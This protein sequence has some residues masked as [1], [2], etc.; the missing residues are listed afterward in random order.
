MN[1]LVRAFTTYI[2]AILEYNSVIWSH[3]PKAILS[4]WIK[5]REELP[6]DFRDLIQHLTYGQRLKQV[7]LP[8]LELRRL[9]A[10]L[11][12]CFKILFGLVKLSYNPTQISSP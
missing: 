8:S 3:T 11:I 9:H 4:V 7:N 2:R 5:F 6:N 12:M 10:D 1:L